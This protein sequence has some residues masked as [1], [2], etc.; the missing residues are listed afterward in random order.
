MQMQELLRDWIQDN[1]E[2][3]K[4]ALEFH[5][6]IV[7]QWILRSTIVIIFC[8]PIVILFVEPEWMLSNFPAITSLG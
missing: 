6:A 8:S 1:I 7:L 5:N 4:H 2:V 3:H